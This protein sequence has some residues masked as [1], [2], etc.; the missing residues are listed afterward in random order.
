M[1][2]VPYES[3]DQTFFFQST[4]KLRAIGSRLGGAWVAA[5]RPPVTP[6]W[7]SRFLKRVIATSRQGH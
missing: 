7:P 4:E 2:E 6:A 5:T 3:V 1:T